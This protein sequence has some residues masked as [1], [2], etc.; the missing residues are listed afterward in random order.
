MSPD[1]AAAPG[2][3]SADDHVDPRLAQKREAAQF[4]IQNSTAIGEVA[5]PELA[6]KA[7]DLFAGDPVRFNRLVDML[8]T[9][10]VEGVHIGMIPEKTVVQDW[11]VCEDYDGC[12]PSAWEDLELMPWIALLAEAIS[13]LSKKGKP[14][15]LD[16]KGAI[17]LAAVTA[18]RN[19]STP[20]IVFRVRKVHP[21]V[22]IDLMAIEGIGQLWYTFYQSHVPGTQFPVF[23]AL[24]GQVAGDL[25]PEN[26]EATIARICEE[27]DRRIPA[28]TQEQRQTACDNVRELAS[29]AQQTAQRNK[30][31]IGM[32]IHYLSR[33]GILP[34]E[35]DATQ[36][37][38][39]VIAQPE[40]AGQKEV[41]DTLFQGRP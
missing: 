17:T 31:V 16:H 25:K 6:A 12:D 19:S 21:P 9:L 18:C 28:M 32:A 23:T 37:R 38:L 13:D 15:S 27:K 33:R 11:R 39:R 14:V 24:I 30:P 1:W 20:G 26:I 2:A 7:A 34:H 8:A 41:L 22:C 35:Y 4:I 40:Q 29:W 36:K 10:C 5:T 3:R